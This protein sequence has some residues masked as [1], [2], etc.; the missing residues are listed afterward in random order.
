MKNPIQLNITI[1]NLR[2]VAKLFLFPFSLLAQSYLSGTVIDEISG[3][4]IDSVRVS[5]LIYGCSVLSEANGRFELFQSSTTACISDTQIIDSIKEYSVTVTW[6]GHRYTALPKKRKAPLTAAILDLTGKKISEISLS[7]NSSHTFS[8]RTSLAAGVYIVNVPGLGTVPLLLNEKNKTIRFPVKHSTK[9]SIYIPECPRDD[10]I[11]LWKSGYAQIA[12]AEEQARRAALFKLRKKRHLSFDIHN[13]TVLTDGSELPDTVYGRAFDKY[14]LDLCANSEHGG[15]FYRDTLGNYIVNDSNRNSFGPIVYSR[16]YLPRWYILTAFSWPKI[17]GLRKKFPDKMLIQGLEWNVPGHEHASVGII[18][19]EAQPHAIAEFEYRFDFRDI[20]TSRIDLQKHNEIGSHNDALAALAWL[21]ERHPRTSYFFINHPSRCAIG[22]FNVSD[23]RDFNNLAPDICFG[24]EGMPGHHKAYT[25]GSY[26]YYPGMEHR[27]WG[28]ADYMMA[29]VGGLWDALLGEGRRFFVI[30]NSDFHNIGNDFYPGEYAK[31]W[32]TAFDTGAQAWLE[33][34][35]TGEMFIA[36]GDLIDGL[37]FYVDDGVN[38][39]VM[40]STLRTR[41]SDLDMTIRFKSPAKNNNEGSVQ[42]DHIDLIGGSINGIIDPNSLAYSD[43]VNPTTK[44]LKRFKASNWTV[45]GEWRTIRTSI[46][47]SQPT[48]Y[49]LRGT[50]LS[51][52][53]YDELDPEGNPLMDGDGMNSESI[54]WQDLWFYSNPVF[55]Y[56]R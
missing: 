19:D 3:E 7:S 38:A 25:R 13:H 31:T 54:A 5:S 10:T 41:V 16:S 37:E 6:A 52:D 43:P 53:R 22:C 15:L 40:G 39:A 45:D 1:E 18:N 26:G 29:K 46:D 48:Y 44:V 23:F 24:F 11:Y 4:P 47:F 2:H 49:R 33:G 12:I 17:L 55:V 14:N 50:N 34:M 30:V 36:H 8:A 35:R 32:S 42:V 20:D 51:I 56:T 27:T 21:R 28:G 9:L